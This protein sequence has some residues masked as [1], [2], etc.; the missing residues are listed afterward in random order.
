MDLGGGVGDDKCG[1]GWLDGDGNLYEEE[2]LVL[3]LLFVLELV[4]VFVLEYND[5]YYYYYYYVQGGGIISECEFADEG[6]DI[7][8]DDTG[9]ECGGE[10][11]GGYISNQDT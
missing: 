8:N 4:F 6:D 3:E 7:Q 2:L 5:C 10:F 1:D 9:R 11:Y